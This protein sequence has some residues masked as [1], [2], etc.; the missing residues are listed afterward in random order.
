MCG[1][2]RC[3]I[4]ASEKVT[5]TGMSVNRIPRFATNSCAGFASEEVANGYRRSRDGPCRLKFYS[6]WQSFRNNSNAWDIEASSF[7]SFC[8]KSGPESEVE[9]PL[10]ET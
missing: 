6:I 5:R 8:E 2:S 7:M 9:W 4:Y 1:N 10:R 3:K